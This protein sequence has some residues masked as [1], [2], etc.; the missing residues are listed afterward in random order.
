MSD[1]DADQP[2]RELAAYTRLRDDLLV[3]IVGVLHADLRVRSAWL[4]GSFG[5]GE[6]DA[7]SDFDLHVAVE[8]DE[9]VGFW[10]A[11]HRLYAQ[12]G[13]PVLVQPEMKS[14]AQPGAHFQLVVFDGPLEVDWNIGPLSQARR[15]ATSHILLQR[16][17]VAVM[18]QPP[19]SSTERLACL[20]HQLTFFWAM[21]PIAVKYIGRAQSRRAVGLLGLLTGALLILWRLLADADE[22]D[23]GLVATNRVLEP[24]LAQRLPTLGERIDPLECLAV[25]RAQ[26]AEVEQLHAGL[27]A[28]DVAIPSEM[29]EQVSRLAL[30]AEAVLRSRRPAA[31][32]DLQL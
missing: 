17:E 21:A 15:P 18:A 5:R 24:E 16:A 11:R 1:I 9:L 22:P 31:E 10:A 14:N 12:V 29:P 28:L 7:W 13:R 2:E 27:E 32:V 3:R 8:D 25:L 20:D 26:C 23:P 19:L 6:A 30:L 4:S